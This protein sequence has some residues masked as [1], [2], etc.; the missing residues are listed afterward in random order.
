MNGDPRPRRFG[1]AIAHVAV[2]IEVQYQLE[3]IAGSGL[4]KAPVAGQGVIPHV[5]IVIEGEACSVRDK[6]VAHEE[7]ANVLYY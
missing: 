2:Y 5:A 1:E 7:P 6:S 4:S 3:S